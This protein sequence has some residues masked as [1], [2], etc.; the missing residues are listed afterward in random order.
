MSIQ[1]RLQGKP[2]QPLIPDV[3]VKYSWELY[4]AGEDNV[5]EWTLNDL[6]KSEANTEEKLE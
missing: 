2:N 4:I 1:F 6:K 5:L 3:E